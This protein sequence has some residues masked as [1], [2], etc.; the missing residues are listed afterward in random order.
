MLKRYRL[1]NQ[2]AQSFLEVCS[3]GE[4]SKKLTERVNWVLSRG[5]TFEEGFLTVV[6]CP[7][8]FAICIKLLILSD[9]IEE[10]KK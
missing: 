5:S 7:S 4:F 8:S 10:D 3:N 2:E 9:D 6:A 1:K